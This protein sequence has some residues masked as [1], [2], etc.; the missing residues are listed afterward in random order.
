M[1]TVAPPQ[2]DAFPMNGPMAAE[3]APP[4]DAAAVIVGGSCC[5]AY[6]TP[7]AETVWPSLRPIAKLAA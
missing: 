1:M 5:A 4:A 7:A 3:V 6:L 2:K